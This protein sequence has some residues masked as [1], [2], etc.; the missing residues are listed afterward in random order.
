MHSLPPERI[1]RRELHP[2]SHSPETRT[3]STSYSAPPALTP[4]LAH[5]TYALPPS[6]NKLED[7]KLSSGEPL[8]PSIAS[9]PHGSGLGNVLQTTYGTPLQTTYGAPMTRTVMSEC[10][11]EPDMKLQAGE[12]T[13]GAP[14][15]LPVVLGS[16]RQETTYGQPADLVEYQAV[17]V[18]RPQCW[19]FEMPPAASVNQAMADAVVQARQRNGPQNDSRLDEQLSVT[20]LPSASREC[21]VGEWTQQNLGQPPLIIIGRGQDAAN[22]AN[23]RASDVHDLQRIVEDQMMML[24]AVQKQLIEQSAIIQNQESFIAEIQSSSRKE[25]HHLQES[26]RV[27]EG[28]IA[29]MKERM[30]ELQDRAGDRAGKASCDKKDNRRRRSDAAKTL[31]DSRSGATT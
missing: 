22:S 18:R 2:T 14:P 31:A 6:P 5:T 10:S 26:M 11:S 7:S 3:H 25:W 20:V 17:F 16:G 13:Y 23:G 27:F 29:G 21:L 12:T 15:Q 1:K 30:R 4:Q 24:A 28:D 19:S 9:Q 8:T